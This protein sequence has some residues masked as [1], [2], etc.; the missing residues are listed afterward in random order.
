MNFQ[1]AIFDMDG[2]LL[3]TERLCMQVF[4]EACH[5]Q[6]VPFLQDV[7]LGIIGCNAKTIEQIFRNGYGEG[8]DYPA[9]NNEW[10]T[11]YSAIVKNQAIPV[12][13]GV[14]ELLEWLKSNDI[15]IAVA[16][17]TQ[18]DIAKK[19]LELAGLDS[20]FTS[21]STGCEVTHGK[22]HPEIY[23]L[24]AERLGVAPETCLAFE[25]SNNG[26]RASMA[27]NM[28][29]FQIPDLVEPCDEVKALGHTISPSLHHVLTQLQQAA[30]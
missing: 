21:L 17:S 29:S 11:R 1:A 24:A 30:A 4:E 27:A 12:K 8:L 20:Y 28:I 5:A 3:D 14:I 16:T 23:L 9:L 6:G 25:D 10:R 7:Y 15:P 13:D 2:L 26:I 22:P 18:L 19:K